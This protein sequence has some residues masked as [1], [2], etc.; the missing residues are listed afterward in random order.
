MLSKVIC[1]HQTSPRKSKCVANLLQ[2]ITLHKIISNRQSFHFIMT[3]LCCVPLNTTS[4]VYKQTLLYLIFTTAYCLS[5]LLNHGEKISISV[6]K[7]IHIYLGKMLECEE[8]QCLWF[9]D[10]I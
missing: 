6:I 9:V 1:L 2:I 8:Q 4:P 10:Y 3:T 5:I 7:F